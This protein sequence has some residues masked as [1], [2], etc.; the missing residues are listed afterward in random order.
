[1]EEEKEEE[2]EEGKGERG[3][4]RTRKE[5][6][7]GFVCDL[8]AQIL[9]AIHGIHPHTHVQPNRIPHKHNCGKNWNGC[10]P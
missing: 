3:R 8:I 7:L 6:Y 10:N 9:M 4:E 2:E 1:M 5:E